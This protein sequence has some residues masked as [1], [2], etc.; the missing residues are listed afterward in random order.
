MTNITKEKVDCLFVTNNV[1]FLAPIQL[2]ADLSAL[3]ASSNPVLR[4][5]MLALL[6]V[7]SYASTLFSFRRNTISIEQCFANFRF[8]GDQYMVGLCT[9]NHTIPYRRE[10]YAVAFHFEQKKNYGRNCH[11]PHFLR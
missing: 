4:P 8:T 7:Y 9:G 3:V 10:E 11:K 6:V 5:D 2:T 1:P